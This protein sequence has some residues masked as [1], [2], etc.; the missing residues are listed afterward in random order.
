MAKFY[1][2]IFSKLNKFGRCCQSNETGL[3]HAH[4]R[5]CRRRSTDQ[6]LPLGQGGRAAFAIGL[7]IDEMPFL[8]EVIVHRSVY[9][10][11]SCNVFIWRKRSIA[12][13][14]RRN[15]RWLFSAR[16]FIQR[17]ISRRSMLPSSRIAGRIGSQPVLDTDGDSSTW[18]RRHSDRA[19]PRSE[20][21]RARASNRGSARE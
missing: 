15:G 10:A 9:E 18:F 13:S 8:I 11:N 2:Y 4:Q 12:R 7:T 17:P 3:H 20:S 19:M 6:R 16:L 21:G 5:Q 1:L 14:R